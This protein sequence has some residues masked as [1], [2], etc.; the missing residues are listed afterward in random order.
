[1]S[2]EN[3]EVLWS[4]AP[5]NYKESLFTVAPVY[6]PLMS[7]VVSKCIREKKYMGGES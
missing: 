6:L 2:H 7:I 4:K 1:M 3:F 5:N